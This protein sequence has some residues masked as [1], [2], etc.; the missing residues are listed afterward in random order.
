MKR[1][2]KKKPVFYLLNQD[3]QTK[4]ADVI[5]ECQNKD[6]NT[7]V[8]DILSPAFKNTTVIFEITNKPS[9]GDWVLTVKNMKCEFDLSLYFDIIKQRS[10]YSHSTIFM[11][12]AEGTAICSFFRK[13]KRNPT[14]SFGF[15]EKPPKK[16]PEVR[17]S[18]SLRTASV[19]KTLNLF[20]N[21]F[22]KVFSKEFL[23]NKTL[24]QYEVLK[25]ISKS[26][27]VIK[28]SNVRLNFNLDKLI[29]FVTQWKQIS[30]HNKPFEQR[31]CDINITMFDGKLNFEFLSLTFP[32][33]DL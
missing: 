24:Y 32:K 30:K 19:C 2:K 3:D 5:G 10:N 31:F 4:A 16:K 11:K 9:D 33:I 17:M 29:G 18:S 21:C 6:D 8:N 15:I 25:R 13:N 28:C 22:N 7:F 20:V 27:Y 23:A 14:F 26:G 12:R 1:T